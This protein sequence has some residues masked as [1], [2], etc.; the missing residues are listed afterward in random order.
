M[1]MQEEEKTRAPSFV[2]RLWLEPGVG[3]AGEWRGHIREV[4]ADDEAYF[5]DLSMMLEFIQS[6]SQVLVP[7]RLEL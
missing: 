1:L 6:H 3:G 7:L 5:R 2:I 4:H